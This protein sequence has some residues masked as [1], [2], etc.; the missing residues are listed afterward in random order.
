MKETQLLSLLKGQE[1]TLNA[2]FERSESFTAREKENLQNLLETLIEE[3]KVGKNQTRYFLLEDK[4][5]FLA[6][7]T[8]KNRNF[9]VLTVIPSGEEIKISGE[10]SDMLLIGD[11][12]YAKEFQKGTF[13]CLEYLR[14]NSV[15]KGY[16]SLAADG[17]ALLSVDYLN[18]CGKRVFI[19]EVADDIREEVN[20]GDLVKASILTFNDNVLTCKAEE[21][22]V[23]ADEVGSD[24]SM[25]IAKEDAPLHFSKK[26]LTQAENMP[27]EVSDS[28]KE[29]R[30]DFR[31]DC[32][33]T[34][35]GD[36]AHDFDDAVSIRR[37]G[38]GYQITVHIAD[39]TE[40]VKRGSALDEDAITRGTSIYVADRVVPMLPFELSNGICSLNPN[41]DRLT[42]SC[43]MDMDAQ[44]Y[45]IHSEVKRGLIRSHARLTYNQV[46]RFLEGEEQGLEKEVKD[47]LL[48]LA[49]ASACIRRRRDLQ[50]A[51]KLDSTELKFH[52]DEENIPTEV[53][54]MTQGRSEKM[55]E[56]F[57]ILANCTIAKM[58]RERGIPVLYRVHE[59]PPLEKLDTFRSYLKKVRLIK[60]FPKNE[61]ITGARLNDFL[62][63]I[64]NESVRQTV[65]EQML[66]A[67]SKA[68]Y[69]LEDIG[70]FGLAEK[71]YCH[72]TSPI[73]RY[74]D[75]IIHRLVKDYLIDEKK[76][77][78]EEVYLY[79]EKMGTLLSSEEVRADHI[80]RECDD[81]EAAKYMKRHLGEVFDARVVSLISKG[82]FIQTSL[83]IEGFLPY[84]LI[85]GD[86]FRYS[87]KDFTAYGFEK[88]SVYTIG[89]PLRV[90][91]LCVDIDRREIT[92][93]TEEFYDT[94]AFDISDVQKEE[95]AERGISIFRDDEDY[96]E[97]RRT[98]QHRRDH[99]DQDENR[100]F[101][102]EEMERK[103]REISDRKKDD[104][105][106]PTP[107]QWKEVDVIRAVL[108]KY[109]GDEKKVL[110]VLSVMDISEEEYRKLLRF[111]KP[112]EDH[113][114]EG[115]R[116]SAPRGRSSSFHRDRKPSFRSN[117]SRGHSSFR[118]T[119]RGTEK[120][121]SS[122]RSGFKKR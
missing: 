104:G 73:R 115:R 38:S 64:E 18:A 23:K 60:S 89:T 79:L 22:L 101:A 4:G 8:A 54:K 36:D 106:R 88:E 95:L 59:F 93:A 20:Q 112:R 14:P 77:D 71:E 109:P 102:L 98:S 107:E 29:G 37:L 100:S 78:L 70:H 3:G 92:F 19:T 119:D 16:Y 63:S 25:I 94:Y 17:S 103:D 121:R 46:N 42:L 108:A 53:I 55:I 57:M 76:I 111:T 118:G 114:R 11:L 2:L 15:L 117:S 51:M 110:E 32:V 81:L 83:G 74:P 27:I 116:S 6:K 86:A 30:F 26:A 40:Y 90:K 67:M 48:L 85:S 75:D 62:A 99:M 5:Y 50:G 72:F 24:I 39:V 52:L 21:I 96:Y 28:E 9:V 87:E 120:R 80:Q 34:I 113:K 56:D 35:D 41:V 122:S 1:L 45:V 13:H 68:Y 33:V 84:R 65:S 105:F 97:R 12:V 49:E 31:E 82:M 47:T 7:I 69:S 10:E 66:R 43:I 61:N 44:G 58:L 91:A